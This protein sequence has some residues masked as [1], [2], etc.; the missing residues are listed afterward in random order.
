LKFLR[1]V[2]AKTGQLLN[3]SDIAS[4]IGISVNTAKSWIS[5]LETSGIIFLLQPYSNNITIRT[6]KTTKIYFLDT[7]LACY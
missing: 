3:Y 6:I 2:A 4:N 7:G 5:I 1:V